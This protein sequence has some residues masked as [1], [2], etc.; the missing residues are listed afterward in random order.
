MTNSLPDVS[1][2]INDIDGNIC[3]SEFQK[4]IYSHLIYS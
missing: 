3:Q 4:L 1:D 2:Q